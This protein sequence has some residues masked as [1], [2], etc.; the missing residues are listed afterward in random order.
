MVALMVSVMQKAGGA[1]NGAGSKGCAG[2]VSD[3]ARMSQPL[4]LG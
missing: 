2:G 3:G 4:G 1:T